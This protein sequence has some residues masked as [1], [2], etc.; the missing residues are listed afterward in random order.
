MT[1]SGHEQCYIIIVHSVREIRLL[2]F[3]SYRIILTT[4]MQIATPLCAIF[5]LAIL[6]FMYRAISIIIINYCVALC[7]VLCVCIMCSIVWHFISIFESLHYVLIET[8]TC[9]TSTPTSTTTTSASINNNIEPKRR[10]Q[11]EWL[12]PA[13]ELTSGQ[14]VLRCGVCCGKALQMA[15]SD[16]NNSI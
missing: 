11:C 10:Q 8:I 15:A 5:M 14:W 16:D 7:I 13:K 1:Y 6:I 3:G 12:L 9:R 4:M 2:S